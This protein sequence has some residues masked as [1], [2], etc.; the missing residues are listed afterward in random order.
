MGENFGFC[1]TNYLLR[2]KISMPALP[3]FNAGMLT[4]FKAI[5]L[6]DARPLSFSAIESDRER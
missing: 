6:P 3:D 2:N 1:S 4:F 5:I